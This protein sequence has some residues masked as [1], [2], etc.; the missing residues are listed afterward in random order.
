MNIYVA[1][2]LCRGHCLQNQ[3]YGSRRRIYLECPVAVLFGKLHLVPTKASF[4]G[5]HLGHW[6]AFDC[7]CETLTVRGCPLCLHPIH[8]VPGMSAHE[9]SLC[10][11]VPTIYNLHARALSTACKRLVLSDGFDILLGCD[12]LIDRCHPMPDL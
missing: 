4:D 11:V 9:R 1:V 3:E 10:A 8:I 5:G 2:R 6:A 7:A 12:F